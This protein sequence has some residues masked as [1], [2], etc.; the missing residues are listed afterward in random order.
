MAD[1]PEEAAAYDAATAGILAGLDRR[2]GLQRAVLAEL[3]PAEQLA[4][5]AADDRHRA[6]RR[7]GG[8][9]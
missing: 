6:R 3:S 7:G 5:F 9:R 4:V 8:P 1:T 2:P